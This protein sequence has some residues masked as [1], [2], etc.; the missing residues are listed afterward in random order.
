MDINGFKRHIGLHINAGVKHNKQ[1]DKLFWYE[2]IL[3]DVDLDSGTIEIKTKIGTVFLH[4]DHILQAYLTN[5]WRNIA[6]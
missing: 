6:E 2:G 1:P 4:K 3:K 5:P